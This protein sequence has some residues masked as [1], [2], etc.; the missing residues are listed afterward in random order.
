VA[1]V[2]EG[3][4]L[5]LVGVVTDYGDTFDTVFLGLFGHPDIAALADKV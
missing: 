3:E 2:G 4:K 5:E 1:R